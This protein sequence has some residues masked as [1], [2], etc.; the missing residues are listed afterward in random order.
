LQWNELL[1][2]LRSTSDGSLFTIRFLV[3]KQ[4]PFLDFERFRIKLPKKNNLTM[5]FLPSSLTWKRYDT[6][7]NDH[8]IEGMEQVSSTS[9]ALQQLPGL[10]DRTQTNGETNS[11]TDADTAHLSEDTFSFL[12]VAPIISIPFCT[13]LVVLGIKTT[14]Y[15]LILADMMT[16]GTP[17]NLLGIPAA[18]E[19]PVAVS[20]VL[21]VGSK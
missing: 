20:Q 10:S 11:H 7:T 21:A 13:G 1:P 15:S 3:A 5:P 2:Q 6:N 14:M 18:L 4:N 19:L 16:K 12:I 17:N 8:P 9:I